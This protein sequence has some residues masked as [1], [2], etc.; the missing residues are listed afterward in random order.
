MVPIY[1]YSCSKCGLKFEVLRAMSQ[2]GEDASCPRCG[3]SA[4]RVLSLFSRSSEGSSASGVGSACT[5]CSATTCDSCSLS[6]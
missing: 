1:E 5:S 3:G 2:A 6:G 4:E